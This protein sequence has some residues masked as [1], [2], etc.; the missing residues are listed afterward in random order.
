MMPLPITRSVQ[1]VIV[2]ENCFPASCSRVVL[3]EVVRGDIAT[4]LN[5]FM[6]IVEEHIS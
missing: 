6:V 1:K 2:S 4:V 3:V 5:R